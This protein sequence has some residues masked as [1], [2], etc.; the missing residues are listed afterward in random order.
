MN[1][2]KALFL[3]VLLF[4][5]A[6]ELSIFECMYTYRL[7]CTSLLIFFTVRTLFHTWMSVTWDSLKFYTCNLR[8]EHDMEVK[9]RSIDFSHQSHGRLYNVMEANPGHP[10]YWLFPIPCIRYWGFHTGIFAWAELNLN[11][12]SSH[13][14]WGNE[15]KFA[16]RGGIRPFSGLCMK[17]WY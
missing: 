11:F 5:V 10:T 15:L 2:E 8:T 9:L 1:I 13:D 3:G 17:H 14:S 7:A 12:I 6:K 4:P 16:G